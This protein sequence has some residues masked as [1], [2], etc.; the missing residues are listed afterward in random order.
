[1]NKTLFSLTATLAL[2]MALA[3]CN[4][5]R[6]QNNNQAAAAE[7]SAADST[8]AETPAVAEEGQMAPDFTLQDIDGKSFTLSS[9]RGK[10]VVLDF[11]GSWCPWCLRGLPKMKEYY[12]KYSGRLEIVGIDCME[13]QDDWKACVKENQIPWTHVYNPTDDDSLQRAYRL[14]GYPHKVVIG[15]DGRVLK[16][17]VG[18]VPEFYPYLDELLAAK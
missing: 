7:T 5:A 11:W 17:F 1:M 13:E 8:A 4:N 10:T 12:A 3:G 18:E 6:Q 16:M 14:E 2:S 15:A 9:L